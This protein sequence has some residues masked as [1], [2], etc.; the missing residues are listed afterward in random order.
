MPLRIAAIID[1]VRS[2]FFLVPMLFV[3]AGVLLGELGI[4]IDEAVNDQA[5]DLPLRLT[6]TVASARVV[7]SVVAGATITFASISFSVSLLIISLT[8]S[9]YSP[10]VVHGLFRDPYN[11]RVIGIVVGTF[12]YCL[13]VIR[14]VRGPLEEGGTPVVP[15]LSTGLAVALGLIAIL[16]I[17]AFINHSAHSMDIS[18]ILHRITSETIEQAERL[19]TLNDEAVLAEDAGEPGDLPT[20]DGFVIS[21]G[22]TGWIQQLDIDALLEIVEDGGTLQVEI[23]AGRYAME[24]MPLCTIWPPP[25]DPDAAAHRARDAVQ[26]GESRTMQQ[27]VTYGIRQLADVALKALSPGVNDPTTAQDALFHLGSVVH[28]LLIRRPPEAQQTPSGGRV[29]LLPQRVT[30]E[31]VIGLAFDEVRIAA[32]GQPTVCIYLLGVLHYLLES[33]TA[34]R[35]ADTSALLRRQAEL[36]VAGSHQAGL[37]ESDRERIEAMYESKFNS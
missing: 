35:L 17:V 33:V 25:V 19:W 2:S 24:D 11:K 12:A 30:H 20:D 7:L 18:R 27:D 1:R 37:L 4:T 22:D 5:G 10:R 23:N 14:A 3:I 31:E 13:V 9:Q 8:S 36:V 16:S 28:E 15:S 34:R 21:L 29:L 26:I 6:T 32:I